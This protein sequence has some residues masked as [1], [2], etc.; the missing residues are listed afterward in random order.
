MKTRFKQME[1]FEQGLH[2]CIKCREIKPIDEFSKNKTKNPPLSNECKQ[3]SSEKHKLW[4]KAN[5]EIHIIKT[6][7]Y[8]R[9][10]PEKAKKW[11]I[12]NPE[13]VKEYK[14]KNYFNNFY[15]YNHKSKLWQ[16]NN[17][18]KS[19]EFKRKSENK[20]T[21]LLADSYIKKTIT[22]NCELHRSDITQGL[23]EDKRKELKIKRN[24]KQIKNQIK[25]QNH[26][27]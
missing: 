1:L 9:N 7:V 6:R 23:I 26:D 10:N 11:D 24:R 5:K 14:R 8:K 20:S 21:V 22:N 17:P 16:K 27:N 13:K 19:R 15:L 18:A 3:C 25:N 4:Y 2:A 12:A